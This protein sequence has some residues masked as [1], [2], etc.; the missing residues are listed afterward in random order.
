MHWIWRLLY[1]L[2]ALPLMVLAAYALVPIN[3][4]VR[5]GLRG[6]RRTLRRVTGFREAI[7]DRFGP[8][9]WFHVASLG[10]YEQTRP[11]IDGLREVVP[12]SIIV[13][14]FFSPSGYEH[15][16]HEAVDFVFYLPLDFSWTMRQLLRVLKPQKVILTSYDIWPNLIWNCR[17]KGIPTTLFAARIIPGSTKQWP[18]L[19][20]FYRHI[21]GAISHIYTVSDADHLRIKAIL[22]QH[23]G[24]EVRNLG[25]PRYDRVKERNQKGGQRI[26]R[27]SGDE[28]VIVL[29]SLHKEDEQVIASPLLEILS[30][31]TTIRA[32]WV[33]HE[34]ETEVVD[35]IGNRLSEAGISWEHYSRQ[36]G[37]FRDRQ[38]L[39]IDGVGY[40]AELYGRSDLAYIG[41]GF[42]YNVHNVMEAAIAGIPVLFGP[43]YSRSHEAE[44]LIAHGG[45]ISV[46]SAAEFRH[47]LDALL[48]D[49]SARE[50]T[51][52]AA[53]KVIEANLGASARILQ[54]ILGS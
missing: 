37:R 50:K 34:P 45:G 4:K 3:R 29:G 31:D 16:D 21:F 6:R 47:H 12:E 18:I 26:Q 15:F 36:L 23:T 42:G 43:R 9:F 14:S 25:N 10:E 54:A 32:Y 41:G 1:N 17:Q 22:G 44:E 51:G 2:V 7:F 5:R 48:S 27:K 46:S 13:V 8:L 24:T 40:L 35:A 19:S 38:V 52:A 28:R 53:L 11:V 20:N 49:S 33:P 39:I 30:Q